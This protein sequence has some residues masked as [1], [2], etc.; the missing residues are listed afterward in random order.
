MLVGGKKN[1]TN[2]P[3]IYQQAKSVTFIQTIEKHVTIKI[4]SQKAMS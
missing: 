1:S 3:T 2:D 4:V